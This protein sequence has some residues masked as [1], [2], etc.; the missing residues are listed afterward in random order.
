[1]PAFFSLFLL[2]DNGA[3]GVMAAIGWFGAAL[4]GGCNLDCNSP[5]LAAS[6]GKAWKLS[7]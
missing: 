1:M 6:C 5:D 3:G 4:V 7:D 2:H